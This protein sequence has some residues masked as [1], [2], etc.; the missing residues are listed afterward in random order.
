MNI[1]SMEFG[2]TMYEL[3]N[4]KGEVVHQLYKIRDPYGNNVY[5]GTWN[6]HDKQWTDS[7][8]K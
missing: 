7:F 6:K 3:K 5:N 8:K 2:K 4:N 1:T